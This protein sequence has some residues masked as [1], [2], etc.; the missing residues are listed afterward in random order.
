MVAPG[1][2]SGSFTQTNASLSRPV[3]TLDVIGQQRLVILRHEADVA[4]ILLGGGELEVAVVQP[5]QDDRGADRIGDAP[6]LAVVSTVIFLR[7]SIPYPTS[8]RAC[9]EAPSSSRTRTNIMRFI[10]RG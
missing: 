5:D 9:A 8:R 10:I 2:T 7:T 3:V 6:P 4:A 1:F